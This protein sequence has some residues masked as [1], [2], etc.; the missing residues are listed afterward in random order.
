MVLCRIEF[1]NSLLE[2]GCFADS[3][4]GPDDAVLLPWFLL[5]VRYVRKLDMFMCLGALIWLYSPAWD[6]VQLTLKVGFICPFVVDD[7]TCLG[8]TMVVAQAYAC[9]SSTYPLHRK[10]AFLPMVIKQMCLCIP[11][12]AGMLLQVSITGNK[13]ARQNRH[14]ENEF[15]THKASI[16]F[17]YSLLPIWLICLEQYSL[18]FWLNGWITV[19]CCWIP[20]FIQTWDIAFP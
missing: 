2:V 3:M 5:K 13:H 17:C 14:Q 16:H 19:K 6:A 10:P 20:T 9:P 8:A 7:P 12:N 15:I 18:V 4:V 1:W 11:R